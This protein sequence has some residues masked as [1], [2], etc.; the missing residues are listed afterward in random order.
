M[1]FKHIIRNRKSTRA[2]LDEGIPVC[3]L[4]IGVPAENHSKPDRKN[5]L[6]AKL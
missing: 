2:F 3:I 6:K 4:P 1:D 5:R